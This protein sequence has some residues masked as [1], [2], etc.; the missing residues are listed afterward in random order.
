MNNIQRKCPSCQVMYTAHAKDPNP[1]CDACT[2]SDSPEL[3]KFDT[4]ATPYWCTHK[5]V[6]SGMPKGKMW[7]AKCDIDY[8][9]KK[10]GKVRDLAE[11]P[12]G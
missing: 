6:W 7:C 12:K 9:E 8:D 5:W 2:L 1:L 4:S 10:H 11:F 3:D